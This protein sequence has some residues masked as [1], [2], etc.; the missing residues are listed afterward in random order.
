M[1]KFTMLYKAKKFEDHLDTRAAK[2]FRERAAERAR[3]KR[4]KETVE[5]T[6]PS[7]FMRPRFERK[8]I[9][10]SCEESNGSPLKTCFDGVDSV[11]KRDEKLKEEEEKSRFATFYTR[12]SVVDIE[13]FKE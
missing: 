4:V 6:L 3:K 8:S 1:N 11:M 12:N 5:A 13:D 9:V 10:D 2:L 7:S